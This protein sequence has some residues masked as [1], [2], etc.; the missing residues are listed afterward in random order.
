MSYEASSPELVYGEY[1]LIG[2]RVGFNDIVLDIH[3]AGLLRDMVAQEFLPVVNSSVLLF[4]EVQDKSIGRASAIVMTDN[5]VDPQHFY[6]GAHLTHRLKDTWR[7]TLLSTQFGM[8][9]IMNKDMVEYRLA[10]SDGMV[11]EAAKRTRSIIDMAAICIEDVLDN[12]VDIL[13]REAVESPISSDDVWETVEL[14]DMI[15]CHTKADA[16]KRLDRY[17]P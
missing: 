9:D 1:E 17:L 4:D 7:L 6:I 8:D 2:P 3:T 5:A 16:A 15:V 11:L 14:L 10:L 12:K 13:R